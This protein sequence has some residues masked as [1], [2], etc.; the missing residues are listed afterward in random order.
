MVALALFAL[1]VSSA[2]GEV[3]LALP[4]QPGQIAAPVTKTAE[5]TE[6]RARRLEVR[7]L[8]YYTGG[9]ATVVST[10]YGWGWGYPRW[11]IGT[12]YVIYDPVFEEHTWA[13]YQGSNRLTVPTYLSTVGDQEKLKPLDRSIRRNLLSSKILLGT[14]VVGVVGAVAGGLGMRMAQNRQAFSDYNA[15]GTTSAVVAVS[16]FVGH[17]IA[18]GVA[19]HKRLDFDGQL[20]TTEVREQVDGFN[21]RLRTDLGL[22]NAEVQ[23]ILNADRNLGGRR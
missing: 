2:Q 3:P 10:G 16:G 1:L 4:G 6:F 15:I 12:S 11:G 14:G 20:N 23:P 13:V 19:K 22:T 17:W 21:D 9:G 7:A 5:I 8:R 18:N